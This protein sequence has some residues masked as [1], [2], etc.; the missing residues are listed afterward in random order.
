[1][2]GYFNMNLQQL[3]I[4]FWARKGLII[5]YLL[6]TMITTLV[7]SLLM[8]KQ[9]I[10]HTSLVLD[11]PNINP[12]TGER[13]SIELT[14]AY[15]ATQSDIIKSPKVA[16]VAVDILGLTKDKTVEANFKKANATGD[17]R[18]WL[19]EGLMEKLDVTPSRESSIL[20][21]DFS[22]TDAVF[23]AKAANAFAQ[24]YIKV[25]NELKR[26]PAQQTADWFEEQLETSRTRMEKAREE[27]S[28]FQQVHSIIA[29][30]NEQID[31]ED[32]KLKELSDQLIKNQLQTAELVSKKKQLEISTNSAGLES[33]SE[34]LNNALLQDLK[35]NL[36]R[37]EAKF[38]DL[39]IHVDKNHPQY[40]QA[41]AE[42]ANLKKTN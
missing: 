9:Y 8:S 34:V 26:Q 10:A 21:I 7:L 25:A 11:Q 17:F 13:L 32:A 15:M 41:A 1:M 16:L 3:L 22:A 33:L 18:Y 29:T 35:A 2:N 19:A 31:L 42:V 40:R 37:T 28:S 6:V 23:S 36:A 27:L 14:A 4:V 39:A 38:A 20:G 24:A 12:I 5:A 30:T